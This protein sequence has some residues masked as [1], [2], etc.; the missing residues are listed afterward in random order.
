M[1]GASLEGDVVKEAGKIEAE[2]VEAQQGEEGENILLQST[3][4]LLSRQLVTY[5]RR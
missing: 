3:E 5:Y 4:L 1:T 2:A